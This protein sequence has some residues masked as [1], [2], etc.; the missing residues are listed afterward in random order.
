MKRNFARD[1]SSIEDFKI[2]KYATNTESMKKSVYYAFSQ[3]LDFKQLTEFPTDKQHL[4]DILQ[5]Y[6]PNLR[7]AK[8]DEEYNASSLYTIRQLLRATIDQKHNIDI[9]DDPIFKISNNIFINYTKSLKSKG[10]GAITHYPVITSAD[11]E[12]IPITLNENDPTQLQLLVWFFLQY[13]SI[14][15]KIE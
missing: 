10:K 7:K 4:E 15:I 3:Y 13:Y 5:D 14:I 1:V 6:W 11:L 8:D 12:K 9:L 2:K